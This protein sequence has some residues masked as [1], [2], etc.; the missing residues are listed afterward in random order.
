MSEIIAIRPVP[1]PVSA[2]ATSVESGLGVQAGSI[3]IDLGSDPPESLLVPSRTLPDGWGLMRD[4]AQ[5]ADTELSDAGW[6]LFFLAGEIEV[7]VV[8]LDRL[9]AMRV[10]MNRVV[11]KVKSQKCNSFEVARVTESSFLGIPRVS[12]YGHVRNLQKGRLLFG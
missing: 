5:L 10:A 11:R 6:Y 12:V 8:R 2:R 3:L 7:T 4:P 1:V 9:E